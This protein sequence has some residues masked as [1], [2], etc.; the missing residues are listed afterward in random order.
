MKRLIIVLLLIAV[1]GIVGIVRS[2]TRTGGS[3]GDLSRNIAAGRE[4]SGDKRE[5]IRK[6]VELAPGAKVSILGINGPVHISA[7]DNTTAEVLVERFGKSQEALDRRSVQIE[8]TP[9]SL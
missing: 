6:S 4:S 3:F 2:R 9:S 7:N 8:S 1:A 5:E